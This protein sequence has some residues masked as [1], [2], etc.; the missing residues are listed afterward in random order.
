[1]MFYWWVT[2]GIPRSFLQPSED[3]VQ[4]AKINPQG[5]QGT[6]TLVQSYI[7]IPST[8]TLVQGYIHILSRFSYT[9]SV[10]PTYSEY[11][12]IHMYS[13]AYLHTQSTYICVQSNKHSEHL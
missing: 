13:D 8:S 5:I 2:A 7:Q 11:S 4:G 6:Y 3:T 10:V 1:M 12:V 9:Y